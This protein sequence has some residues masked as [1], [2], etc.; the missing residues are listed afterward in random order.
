MI[1][2][3]EP[4]ALNEKT[5]LHTILAIG[6]SEHKCAWWSS[7]RT[8]KILFLEN[9]G[10]RFMTGL[11]TSATECYGAWLVPEAESAPEAI[12]SVSMRV[13]FGDL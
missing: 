4:G 9:E 12:S 1:I 13:C 3:Q 10:S 11:S 5:I 7:Q 6:N 8:K 2:F